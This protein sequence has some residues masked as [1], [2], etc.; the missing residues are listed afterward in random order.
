MHFS[1]LEDVFASLVVTDDLGVASAAYNATAEERVDMVNL[2]PVSD[3]RLDP[4]APTVGASVQFTDA[5]TD[6]DGDAIT[7][8]A[9]DFGDGS[10]VVA[11]QN[12]THTFNAVGAYKVTL[13]VTD[14]PSDGD[15]QTSTREFTVFVCDET[16][17][18]G[19]ACKPPNAGPLASFSPNRTEVDQGHSVA[20]TDASEDRDGTIEAWHW[21][22]GDGE[23]SSEQNP[24]HTFTRVG[25]FQV[26][27]TV[28]DDGGLQSTRAFPIQ[29]RLVEPDPTEPADLLPPPIA[30]FTVSE[31]PAVGE[32]VTFTDATQSERDL[33][34]WT[35]FFGDGS[36]P[37]SGAT[38]EHTYQETGTFR[39]TLTVEDAAG[40]RD[41]TNQLVQV[42]SG[43]A[44]EESPGV[45]A[46]VLLAALG[47]VAAAARRRDA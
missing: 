4:L 11:T 42:G 5:S 22:F 41:T 25:T 13:T 45:P 14:D 21:D 46:V 15:R 7:E 19:T 44:E 33:V 1:R 43:D 36:D 18:D 24:T 31:D 38:V 8:W 29:V 32:A 27:L 6:P 3:F 28:T 37:A 26:T 12:P 16:D 9:W 34:S 10:D 47:A 2:A 20:F 17:P 35:W 40:V 39:V 23:T 30:A